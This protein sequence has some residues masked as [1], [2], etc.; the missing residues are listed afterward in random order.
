MAKERSE[1]AVV[2]A[3]A[4]VCANELRAQPDAAA[5]IVA[6]SKVDLYEDLRSRI[7]TLEAQRARIARHCAISL[8][9][10]TGASA[11]R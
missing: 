2:A 4:P 10:R 3:L 6:V 11:Q 5:K 7:E 1:A 8:D 9:T